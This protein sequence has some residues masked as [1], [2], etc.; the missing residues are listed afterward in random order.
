MRPNGQWFSVPLEQSDKSGVLSVFLI[1]QAF[2]ENEILTIQTT[3]IEINSTVF[4]KALLPLSGRRLTK[5][6]APCPVEDGRSPANTHLTG[7]VLH[8][9]L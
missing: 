5:N 7:V 4:N 1:N 8:S 2:W 6:F 9:V 3:E